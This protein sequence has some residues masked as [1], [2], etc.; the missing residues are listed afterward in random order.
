MLLHLYQ[1]TELGLEELE[2]ARP[3]GGVTYLGAN[4]FQSSFSLSF[5]RRD[6]GGALKTLEVVGVK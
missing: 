1:P 3:N 6:T 5:F 2:R 4:E